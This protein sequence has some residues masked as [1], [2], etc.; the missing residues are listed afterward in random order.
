[1]L[2]QSAEPTKCFRNIFL[3]FIL[4]AAMDEAEQMP[5]DNEDDDIKDAG[6]EKGCAPGGAVTAGLPLGQLPGDAAAQASSDAEFGAMAREVLRKGRTDVGLLN[7]DSRPAAQGLPR[8]LTWRCRVALQQ[9]Q[10]QS[11]RTMRK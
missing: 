3:F 4:S 2:R 1:M 10:S 7:G 5:L 11:P 9:H 8:L 6:E